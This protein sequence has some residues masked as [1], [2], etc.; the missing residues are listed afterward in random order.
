MSL[1][2]LIRDTLI[3]LG[4]P[5]SSMTA[6]NADA[7]YIVFTE[8]NQAGDLIA[9]DD[10]L[11]TGY[12]IQVDVFSS[13]NFLNLVKQVKSS[14]KQVGFSR[15]YESETYDDQAEKFRKIIRFS[16]TTDIEEEI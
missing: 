7:T 10:E 12:F 8:Y 15:M 13:G 5:V 2:R 11:T 6:N 4:V 16:Y 3:P 9:D 14:M 1:N